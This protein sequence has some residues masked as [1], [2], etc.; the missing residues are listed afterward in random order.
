[1]NVN[2]H[3]NILIGVLTDTYIVEE[4]KENSEINK[5]SDEDETVEKMKCRL[6]CKYSKCHS[7]PD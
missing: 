2:L 4:L 1:M 6:C 7:K 5:D 3:K